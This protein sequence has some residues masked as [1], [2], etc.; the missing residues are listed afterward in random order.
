MKP[1]HDALGVDPNAYRLVHD[2]VIQEY[3]T[4]HAL[5]DDAMLTV[6]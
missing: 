6:R 5:G 1:A 4:S 2:P 3:V